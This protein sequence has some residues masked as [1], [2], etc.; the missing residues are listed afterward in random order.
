MKKNNIINIIIVFGT[1]PEAIKLKSIIDTLKLSNNYKVTI[2]N[3]GQ[4]AELLNKVLRVLNISPDINLDVMSSNQNLTDITS[5]IIVKFGEVLDSLSPDCVLVHGDTTTSFAAALACFYRKVFV[6]HVEAGLRTG[7]TY[8]PWPEEGNRKLISAIA[9]AHFCPTQ[10][11]AVNLVNE[12]IDKSI[13]KITGNTVIDCLLKVSNEL[14]LP[15]SSILYNQRFEFLAKYDGLIL[16]T[17]HR[18]ENFGD[19]ILSICESLLLIAKKYNNIAIVY[20]VHLNPHILIPVK[21]ILSNISNVYL[22]DPVDYYEFVYLLKNSKI[23][24]T[25]SGGIQEEAPTFGVPVLVMREETERPEAIKAG[26]AKLVGNNKENILSE[27][28][29]LLTD[30]FEYKRMSNCKNPFGD[31]LA[32]IRIKKHLDSIFL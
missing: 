17:S 11:S 15:E 5:K 24:L 12:G 16:V 1:R 20:P 32:A 28:D 8:S 23:I 14:G 18:R 25:D 9:N 4:H 3:T 6:G 19:G 22:I 7:D 10:S 27:V 30:S 13:I 26:T 29:L 21:K 2:C 31:G